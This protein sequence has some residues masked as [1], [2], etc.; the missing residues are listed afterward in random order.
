ME[1]KLE[2]VA[3]KASSTAQPLA[4]EIEELSRLVRQLAE[5]VAQHETGA[6]PRP[7][8][9][10]LPRRRRRCTRRPASAPSRRPS[11][12]RPRAPALP[13]IAAFA[14]LAGDVIIAAVRGAID[15]QRIDLHLQPI[16]TLPQRKVRYYEALSRLNAGSGDMVA[17]G[18]F[19][20]LCR[21][22]FA[23]AEARPAFGVSLRADRSAAVAQE[24]RD[25][26]VLQCFRRG[27]DRCRLSAIAGIHRG[28]SRARAVAGVRVHAKRSP[29]HGTDGARKPGGACRAGISLFHG[30]SHRS[31]CRAARTD[32]AR[33]SLR[34]GFGGVAAQP[35]R[36]R[37]VPTFIRPISP[38]CSAVSASISSPS[39]SRAS[40]WWSTFSTTMSASGR[41]SCFR[42]R[43]RCA[44]RLCRADSAIPARAPKSAPAAKPGGEAP[45]R[46]PAP[47]LSLRGPPAE[48]VH[49]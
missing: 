30:Q 4:A 5:S 42:R 47:S 48:P 14:G 3:D 43:A 27:A 10:Q 16:V 18:G 23:A 20:A 32:G 7:R 44:R 25:R 37:H 29:Q 31:S 38:T 6:R 41:A 45:P 40:R 35:R 13:E 17:A 15:A 49:Q 33:L 24:P 34:Q 22:R 1:S 9:P 2:S 46:A 19:P 26:L 12:P 21:S 11:R 39:G 36:Q 8:A 28:Q